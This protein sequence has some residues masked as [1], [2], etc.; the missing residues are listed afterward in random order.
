M[1]IKLRPELLKLI[2]DLSVINDSR[3][4]IER[5]ANDL[6]FLYLHGDL[7]RPAQIA[8]RI[9]LPTIY[10]KESETFDAQ[11]HAFAGVVVGESLWVPSEE[12]R[13]MLEENTEVVVLN[14][15]R[16]TGI[17]RKKGKPR[18]SRTQ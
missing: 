5:L 9:R 17:R 13:D 16:K 11:T 3:Q 2:K 10:R 1:E 12:L 18:T 6:L 7:I 15:P 8:A 14:T 4:S